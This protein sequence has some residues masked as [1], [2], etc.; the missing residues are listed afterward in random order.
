MSIFSIVTSQVALSKRV[1]PLFFGYLQSVAASPK[2]GADLVGKIVLAGK[3]LGA[4]FLLKQFAS[5]FAIWQKEMYE[6]GQ[7]HWKTMNRTILR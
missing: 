4:P 3:I 1:F 5:Y 6:A 2:L 7:N